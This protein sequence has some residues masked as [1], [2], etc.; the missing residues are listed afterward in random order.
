MMRYKRKVPASR[1]AG[2]ERNQRFKVRSR[3][4][5]TSVK[6]DPR[7]KIKP[8]KP[9]KK[10]R[11]HQESRFPTFR[12]SNGSPGGSVR[13]RRELCS[14]P[15]HY[16]FSHHRQSRQQGRQQPEKSLKNRRSSPRLSRQRRQ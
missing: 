13:S 5:V 7:R 11:R 8:L 3:R 2:P 6:L 1:S 12:N 16:S 14:R 4:R 10:K 9:P 15:S